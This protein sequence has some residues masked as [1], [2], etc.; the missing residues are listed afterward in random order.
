MQR[1]VRAFDNFRSAIVT[2]NSLDQL[3]VGFAGAFGD[4]NITGA[5]QIAWRLAQGS[6]RQQKF[7]SKRRLPIDQHNIEPM[8]EMKILQTVVEQQSVGV[9]FFYGEQA[10]LDPV[11]VDQDG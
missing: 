7:V 5:P 4:E 10:A 8:F 6:A 2:S 1:F 3:L 9:H 11:L